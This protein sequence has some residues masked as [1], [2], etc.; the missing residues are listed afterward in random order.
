[1]AINEE[2][3]KEKLQ[4]AFN[5]VDEDGDG[6]ISHDDLSAVCENAGLKL[7]DEQIQ[8]IHSYLICLGIQ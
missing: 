5:A 4:E 1:M 7:S 3:I 6:A 2:A 8:V